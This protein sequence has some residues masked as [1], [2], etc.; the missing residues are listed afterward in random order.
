MEHKLQMCTEEIEIPSSPSPWKKSTP[1]NKEMP[2][3][4]TAG[5]V[6][7][8]D[9]EQVRKLAQTVYHAQR[10]PKRNTR[11]ETDTCTGVNGIEKA[12]T[13]G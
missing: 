2:R 12:R 11:R 13:T 10:F 5:F 9:R 8:Q 3:A 7:H 1:P 6:F 4:I